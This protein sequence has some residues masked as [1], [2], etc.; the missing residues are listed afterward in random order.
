MLSETTT[1][2]E[3]RRRILLGYLFS[4]QNL[5]CDPPKYPFWSRYLFGD[6]VNLRFSEEGKETVQKHLRK[7]CQEPVNEADL[8]LAES[9]L[10]GYFLPEAIQKKTPFEKVR[11]E[12]QLPYYTSFLSSDFAFHSR[13]VAVCSFAVSLGLLSMFSPLGPF[14]ALGIAGVLAMTILAATGAVGFLA[15]KSHKKMMS[16][17]LQEAFR[18]GKQNLENLD[19]RKMVASAEL[20]TQRQQSAPCVTPCPSHPI[21]FGSISALPKPGENLK[22]LLGLVQ[23]IY[24]NKWL[25]NNEQARKVDWLA[26]PEIFYT[27]LPQAPQIVKVIKQI[28]AKNQ[29]E[30]ELYSGKVANGAKHIELIKHLDGTIQTGLQPYS[31]ELKLSPLLLLQQPAPLVAGDNNGIFANGSKSV[32][33]RGFSHQQSC[34]G[35]IAGE[36]GDNVAPSLQIGLVV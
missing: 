6:R 18:K 15:Y 17:V 26:E 4:L 16:R 29:L 22:V 25:F 35:S 20:H 1:Q 21:F 31:L 13:T 19:A 30:W 5:F 23:K 12:Y 14:I 28:F 32:L 27:E 34:G 8:N 10:C 11:W 3:N 33:S 9:F 7:L 2:K 36:V 24:E